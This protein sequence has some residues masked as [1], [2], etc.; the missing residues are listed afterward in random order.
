[1][2]KR[3]RPPSPSPTHP[4]PSSPPPLESSVY[5]PFAKRRRTIGPIIDRD[6]RRDETMMDHEEDD[7]N[8][9]YSDEEDVYS[10]GGTL[11]AVQ[12]VKNYEHV[13][14]ILHNLHAEQQHRLCT[15]QIHQS[16]PS[17][18]AHLQSSNSMSLQH[19][20]QQNYPGLPPLSS[21]AGYVLSS[22]H[23]ISSAWDSVPPS[24]QRQNESDALN[25]ETIPVAD[26]PSG[27][28][29]NVLDQ[30]RMFVTHR[31]E[32]TNRL[33]GS[34]VLSRR[35]ILRSPSVETE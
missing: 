5:L 35:R 6:E 32:D 29:E 17:A 31:Y 26:A 34:L 18:H 16:S 33:L 19:P 12:S 13:N 3:P 1:M 2:L 24:S 7:C 21:P 14:H 23:M 11:T 27:A 28:K 20:H 15:A 25:T 30:E 22:H 9:D 8:E 10:D 4:D